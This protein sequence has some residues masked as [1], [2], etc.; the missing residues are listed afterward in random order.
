[1]RHAVHAARA[2]RLDAGLL[3]RFE[4]RA[5]LLA[6]RLQTAMHRGVV[7]GQAQGH[8]VGIAAHDRGLGAGQFARRL[9]QPRFAAHQA[10]TLGGKGH[11]EIGLARQRAHG[12][13]R[14]PA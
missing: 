4:H 11:F 6:G 1:M 5:R 9:R 7:A 10:G 12:S 14:P 3:D 2:D 13:R 8:R